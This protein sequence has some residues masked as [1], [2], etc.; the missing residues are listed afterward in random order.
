MPSINMIMLQTVA[1]GLGELNKD[2]DLPRHKGGCYAN[3]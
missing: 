2:V 1:E 3:R